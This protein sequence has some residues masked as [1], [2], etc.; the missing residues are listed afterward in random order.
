MNECHQVD[1][2][3]QR[4]VD[5]V[6]INSTLWLGTKIFKALFVVLLLA[7]CLPG[8]HAQLYTGSVSGTVTDPSAA[9]VPSAKMTLVDADKGFSYTATTDSEGRYL[10]RQI[11]PGTYNLSVEAVNFQSQRKDAIKLDVSQNVSINFALKIGLAISC[12]KFAAPPLMSP[13]AKFGFDFSRSCALILWRARTQSR[14]P[15]ANRSI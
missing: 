3:W 2:T 1:S 9:A 15:G 14:K 4:V 12:H 5:G 11:P 6:L 8:L 10:F 7:I 13:P